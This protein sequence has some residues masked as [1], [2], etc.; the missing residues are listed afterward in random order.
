ML[1][2]RHFL[3][4]TTPSDNEDGEQQDEMRLTRRAWKQLKR[5]N[6]L[7]GFLAILGV[8][9]AAIAI[10]F[11]V[12]FPLAA[13][14]SNTTVVYI[15]G[16]TAG[17]A[18]VTSLVFAFAET[19]TQKDVPSNLALFAPGATIDFRRL[20]TF[21]AP[22]NV[23]LADYSIGNWGQQMD[24]FF[25]EFI[26]NH[27]TLSNCNSTLLPVIKCIGYYTY[28][29]DLGPTTL[30]LPTVSCSFTANFTY[31]PSTY[32]LTFAEALPNATCTFQWYSATGVEPPGPVL[33]KKRK[34]TL[35]TD[36]IAWNTLQTQI[37]ALV[38]RGQPQQALAICNTTQYVTLKALFDPM[39]T[40]TSLPCNTLSLP[41][42]QVVQQLTCSGQGGISQSCFPA[43]LTLTS[44]TV[45]NLTVSTLVSQTHQQSLMIDTL[46]LNSSLVC[47]SN[48]SFSD[49]CS[50]LQSVNTIHGMTGTNDFTIMPGPGISITGGTHSLTITNVGVL[51]VGLTAPSAEFAVAGSPVTGGSGT[52]M[53]LKQ[54]QLPNTVWAGP[55]TGVSSG[56]PGF[57][58]L[59]SADLPPVPAALVTGTLSVLHGGT[60]N[61]LTYTGNR[62]MVSDATGLK[63]VEGNLVA[64]LGVNITQFPN[65]MFVVGV[66]TTWLQS[67]RFQEVDLVVPTDIFN[68]T[69]SRVLQNGTLAFAAR[70][71]LANHV[72]AGPVA[73][74]SPA[75]VPTF[76]LLDEQDI[77][78]LNM[79]THAYG[80]LPVLHG[81]TNNPG[82][83]LGGQIMV[84]SPDGL[85]IIEAALVAGPGI[86]AN[87]NGSTVSISNTGV[88]SVG[89][90]APTSEFTVTSSPV[91][92]NSGTLSFVKNAQAAHTVWAGPAVSGPN[93]V[94]VFRLLTP[95]DIPTIV[96]SSSSVS[97]ILPISS[98]GTGNGGPFIGKQ[99]IVSD[100]TGT[101]LKEAGIMLDGSIVIGSSGGAP[102]AAQITGNNGVSIVNGP[103][104]IS[105]NALGTCTAGNKFSA[106]CL[107]ISLQTCPGGSLDPT[108]IPQALSVTTLGV[109]GQ[110]VLGTNTTCMAPLSSSCYDISNQACPA[111]VLDAS[112][113]PTSFHFANLT[114]D[115][116][117]VMNFTTI[118]ANIASQDVLNVTHLQAGDITLTG[119]MTCTAPGG[120]AI[121]PSCFSLAN[122]VCPMGMP[123]DSSC[124][125]SSLTLYNAT[126]VNSLSVASLTCNAGPI[127]STCIAIDNKT[128]SLA[129]VDDSCM[130][131][132]IK[133]INGLS[134]N[135]MTL[136]FQI[137]VSGSGLSLMPMGNGILLSNTGVV[138]VGLDAP[139]TEF[140][141]S[142]SPVTSNGTLT[143]TKVNQAPNTVWAG[144]VNSGGPSAQPTF[145][146]LDLPDLPQ[147][148]AGYLYIGAGIGN[149]VVAA[150]LVGA[151]GTNIT[152]SNGT[153]IISSL[154]GT[155][156]SVDLAVPS[157]FLSVSSNPI[158]SSGTLTVSLLAQ[159]N[160]VV[161]ASP[162]NGGSGAPTFRS[163]VAADMP[164][165]MDGQLFIGNS[166]G[167][168]AAGTLT[169]GTGILISNGPNSITINNTGVTSVGLLLPASVFSIS[170][171]PV[172]SV[173]TLTAS[174]VNQAAQT[175]FA[176]PTSGGPAS[177]TF[178]AM[179][180]SDLPQIA[181]GSLLLG[182]GIGNS[183]IPASVTGYNGIN[184]TVDT[185][186]G[187]INI[188]GSGGT[189]TMVDLI[190]PTN[191]FFVLGSPLTGTGGTLSVL[192]M[193][194]AK[195][196][197]WAGP[198]SGVDDAP[199]FR[200]ITLSDFA[201]LN[202][203]NGQ[204]LVGSNNSN[205][206]AANL[207]AGS[208]IVI[209]N[210]AGSITISA[211]TN[212]T[213]L[214]TVTSVD[215]TVPS[216]LLQI[217]G[218]PVTS[219][220]TFN[221]TLA[222]Q[223]GN[224]V[225]ASPVNGSTGTP[226]F[227][228]LDL[229]DM[230]SLSTNQFYLG[231]LSGV[232]MVS[233]LVAGPNML[234][235]T[236]G[237]ITNITTLA[238]TKSV[239][240]AIGGP[241]F[242]VTNSLVTVMGTLTATL[243]NQTA[244]TF[245]A[246]PNGVNGQPVFRNI[247]VN[248]LPS[249]ADGQLYI[250]S[251]GVPTVST[252]A[253][254]TG[255]TITPGMGT[256]TITG[257]AGT[258]T[259]VDLT[260]PSS[261][262]VVTGGPITSSGTFAVSLVS[263]LAN[264]VFAAPNGINGVPT[265]RLLVASDIP[266]LDASK[267]TTGILPV[268]RG[269]TNS[270]TALNNNRIMVSSGGAIVEA[271]ALTNGQL[272]I[273]ST[274]GAPVAASLTP[275][276]GISIGAG[277][278]SIT[279]TNSGVRSVAMTVPSFLTI[280]GSPI[281]TVG[282]LALAL[283]S[284]AANT[285]F[286]AP[287]GA[288]GAPTFR[289]LLAADVPNLPASKI[290]SGILAVSVGGTGT[291]AY[292]GNQVL[293]SNA[294]GTAL[295]EAGA[296]LNGQLVIGSTGAAPV[297]STI[298]AGTGISITNGPGSISVANTG[299]TSVSLLLPASVFSVT[300]SP[301][302]TTGT[303][304]ATLVSQSANTVFA[305]PSGSSGTPTFRLLDAA[306]VPNLDTS[307][308]TTGVLPVARGGTNSGSYTGNKLI[309]SN[310]GGTALVEA[311]P[312]LDG[313]L[314]VGNA[315][316]APVATSLIAGSNIVIT[317]APGSI[318]ISTPAM[319]GTDTSV[320]LALP[321]S[322]FS[323]SG[324]PVTTAGVL[325]GSFISQSANTFFAG[326]DGT[327]AVPSFR[328]I[329][330][331]DLPPILLGSIGSNGGVSGTLSIASGGTNSATALN[332]NR[333]MVSSA[334]AIVEATALSNGQVLIGSTGGAPVAAT[335]TAGTG[336]SITNTAGGISIA[337]TLAGGTVTSVGLTLPA[338]VFS[339]S[340]SP[341][342]SSG[343]LTA[344]FTNQLNNTF[345]AGSSTNGVT[346]TPIFRSITLADLPAGISNSLLANSAIT[347][348]GGTAISGGGLVALG[349]SLTLAL[350]M[351][352]LPIEA[353]PAAAAGNYLLQYNATSGIHSS[354]LVSAL[355]ASLASAT[356]ILSIAKGGT[357]SGTALNNNRI[358][359]SS[360][361]SIVEGPALTN[362]QFLL[363][364]TGGAP[365]AG[366]I[367]AGTGI[368]VTL[369]AGSV[370]VSNTG[371]TSVALSVPASIFTVAGSPVTSTGTLAVALATQA[372]NTV[373]AGPTT[374][375]AAAP[376]FRLL[377]AADI[378]SLSASIITSGILA[379]GVGGTGATSFTGNRVI[380]SNAAGTALTS[381]G[382]MNNGFLMIGSTG[383]A[384]V[385]AALT[386]GTGITITNS[387][388]GITIAGTAG[389]VTS[390]GLSMPVSLF[391]VT[392]SPVTTTGTLTVALATQAVNTVFAGPSSGGAAA[393]T[394]RLLTTADLPSGIPN[395]LLANSNVGILTGTGLTGGATVALGGS[396]T[397]SLA[398]TAVTPGVYTLASITVDAQGRITAASSGTPSSG[399]ANT[400]SNVGVGAS[401]VGL[402]L[403]KTGVNLN[404]KNLIAG[405]SNSIV[406]TNDVVNSNVV[407]ET[408][409]SN[410]NHDSLL[411]WSDNK[412]KDHSLISI[413]A[414]EGLGGG[415]D[416]T[417]SRTLQMAV[418]SLTED[419]APVTND[420]LLEYEIS[421]GTHKKVQ[422][423]N[424]PKQ[425]GSTGLI[426]GD[427][428]IEATAD[429]AQ[430]NV[431]FSTSYTLNQVA[432]L[433]SL[434]FY[435][436][437]AVGNLYLGVYNDNGSGNPGTLAATTVSFAPTVGWN[438][439]AVTVPVVLQ[440]G[441]Y[442]LAFLPSSN[443]LAFRKTTTGGTSRRYS[444]TF[445]ALPATWTIVGQ[446][447]T[448]D[449]W[450]L[451]ANF[452]AN[453]IAITAPSSTF[454]VSGSPL[455]S[456]GTISLAYVSQAANTV[457][458]AP[459]GS[460]GVPSFRLLVAADVPNLDVSKLTTGILPIARGGTNSGTALNNNRIMI[461]S[462]GAIVEATALTNG[463][464][465]IG[466]TGN[467]P[468][469]ATLTAGTGIS[470]TNSAGGITVASTAVT[471]VAMT[472]PSILAV[473]G[474]PITSSGTFAITLSSQSA[475]TFFAAPSGSTG[476]PAFRLLVTTDFT[477]AT[478]FGASN[479]QLM[480]GS[481][482]GAPAFNTLTGTTNQ[483]NVANGAGTITLG[484]PQNI[485][486]AATPTFASTTLTATTNQFVLGTTLTTTISA[487]APAASRIITI[488]D[489]GAN[490]N[491]VLNTAG[492]LTVTN[493]ATTGQVLT[494]TGTNT[495]TWQAASGGGG[496]TIFS[497]SVNS[498]TSTSTTT[499][500]SFVSMTSM[501]IT[502]AAGTYFVTFNGICSADNTN[503]VI[504]QYALYSDSTQI[505]STVRDFGNGSCTCGGNDL[506]NVCA[507]LGVITVGG[508]NAI[509]VRF[510]AATSGTFSFYQR[511]LVI[512]KIG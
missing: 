398:N 32:K 275:G 469:A 410:I 122:H 396:T 288:A 85:S 208:G 461:S 473:S 188:T 283:A 403:S 239:G 203:T 331:A 43:N 456:T 467:A 148:D 62:I 136:D 202:L 485:H 88:L 267:I 177:P 368:S 15:G 438:T 423:G 8:L 5:C 484:L 79:T 115:L 361:G 418:N 198:T 392:N 323:I 295:V 1:R 103:N 353:N 270:G 224:R 384:P 83:L 506:R 387:A 439:Q 19:I 390:V 241:L 194:Q 37:N 183:L 478:S 141:V 189:I 52:L 378:P 266:N 187:N 424:L 129:P 448:T 300:V 191:E 221:V 16:G 393:P 89:L 352:L 278:G 479:G 53:L 133:T 364:I 286:I 69:S 488:P 443:S 71:Q 301:V 487:T 207:I 252:L 382:L 417:T 293:V 230:P 409:A 355:P 433:Q 370:T 291:S 46:S 367:T 163:L 9:F 476:T 421:S 119:M 504:S 10:V 84:S 254:G 507:T 299:V 510:K 363:G 195:N 233:T 289:L 475:N 197:F 420:F 22:P 153:I 394:F 483:V 440:P 308:L 374:G 284:Q 274:G 137:A 242:T 114:V 86:Q 276:L 356:G 181:S 97:G 213:L 336:I 172:T 231:S 118:T 437:T 264:T 70:V 261:L 351:G 436:T 371:V 454:T 117:T 109:S 414:G 344:A 309:L 452:A 249:L 165:A 74:S 201:P 273:G 466:S 220:G 305:A 127:S 95:A 248:D 306:D 173:G 3:S 251:G 416:I 280:T 497:L 218:G 419:T 159:S 151:G 255:I 81:G 98:G 96:L 240:L 77:P 45:T 468:A 272:F 23:L 102:V 500:A 441:T 430:G 158:T 235:T 486:S 13:A 445:A 64:G 61:N 362:G 482:G 18:N 12:I 318:I 495:A 243:N 76:R 232:P 338:S 257:T 501:S 68:A 93:A 94:P 402:Y 508:S 271:P 282:T 477:A 474:S 184:V 138:S 412:H 313:Q 14:P 44:L 279:I 328:L 142:N 399:E 65:G 209:T 6:L 110:T 59:V 457:L 333:I 87:V 140:T 58:L 492:A 258:V 503:G 401:S 57:R 434:S 490:A 342:T 386:A 28:T 125:P 407:I 113:I 211:T 425:Y 205:P 210:N 91:N 180:L 33:V 73:M 498:T 325:T 312:L 422:I 146:L 75:A 455:A 260:V 246:A 481:T 34:R 24:V 20:M 179:Q 472:V 285:V 446:T 171:S 7:I 174:F 40:N 442:W 164:T 340:G 294:A 365:S 206:V 432:T 326:A 505:A 55:A 29:Y 244:N 41:P 341:V 108:C 327:T 307:K 56:Q 345:F 335:L 170:F 204:I 449:M 347:I 324:S 17:G 444:Y 250:G 465:L 496:G 36:L 226:E 200:T 292:T 162:A 92:S 369:G 80:I 470:I 408:N 310:A 152:N 459:T 120:G 450:S 373:F 315:T 4:S 11:G 178:R 320:G 480:I 182:T 413:I 462:G 383:A 185:L 90:S 30:N 489:A 429:T 106:S 303:L 54:N 2:R 116:L 404:F 458:A 287:N 38:A 21:L 366:T 227:R 35:A 330:S 405:S 193:P 332:N 175:F 302:T 460:A 451:Y 311:P 135:S 236:T 269:G 376:T 502:P 214:G 234:I 350:N 27:M 176:G 229:A 222:P 72:W 256:L 297:V 128:C 121:S 223:I 397:L 265:F 143:L 263:Q 334:G 155:V 237:G 411:N 426:V 262:F 186:G 509:N 428:A 406:L 101:Q 337:S 512:L 215:L 105:I 317:T 156:T 126:V 245:F 339:V 199:N 144:P 196:T 100:S 379:V 298:T 212:V 464:L 48:F 296:L 321:A 217:A 372:A 225:F 190:V 60:G 168:T 66:N 377:V 388:G 47:G 511:S 259:S 304:T 268:A 358:M 139:S 39:G 130:Q 107:D 491:V 150:P 63:L 427:S 134:P 380:L 314:L 395:S 471:S 157:S 359:V 26:T 316:G 31:E 238:V 447:S 167:S 493:T 494:A 192:K 348:N 42:S 123:L 112:C 131:P 319:N 25:G 147:L 391:S 435:V 145:R 400:A 343:V 154:L 346:T 431:I 349:G 360:A 389:T 354:I 281:T 247:T 169:A 499:S 385:A 160:N 78:T 381:G 453:G 228:L 99:V 216:A 67:V 415:G 290:T 463:Q 82:P 375:A 253:A 132:R 124:I 277:A 166:L 104:S 161:F 219:A 149:A 51:A 322:V 50:V 111:G 329:V 357:N 49:T